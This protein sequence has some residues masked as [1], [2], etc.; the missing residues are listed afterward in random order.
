MGNRPFVQWAVA[1]FN[2]SEMAYLC[3]SRNKFI[4]GPIRPS[5]NWKGD[6]GNN[7]DHT[8]EE[9]AEPE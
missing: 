5:K 1:P 7:Q 9:T 6:F 3:I 2:I 4:P 8:T